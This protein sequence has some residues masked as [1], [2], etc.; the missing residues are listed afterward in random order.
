M[1]DAQLSR[2]KH[3]VVSDR[4]VRTRSLLGPNTEAA[5]THR[6]PHFVQAGR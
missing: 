4:T 5:S 1:L 3:T 2:T 6:M